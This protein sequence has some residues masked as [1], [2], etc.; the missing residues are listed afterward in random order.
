MRDTGSVLRRASLHRS[1][2]PVEPI[3]YQQI[4]YRPIDYRRIDYRHID[5]RQID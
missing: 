4:D 5:Y 1:L 3:D 2:G